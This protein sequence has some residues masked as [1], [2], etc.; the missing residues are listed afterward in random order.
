M[1]TLNYS[2]DDGYYLNRYHREQI[3]GYYNEDL[4]QYTVD[5]RYYNARVSCTDRPISVLTFNINENSFKF[6]TEPPTLEEYCTKLGTTVDKNKTSLRKLI[7]KPMSIIKLSK[8][9][10]SFSVFCFQPALLEG[11]WKEC[12]LTP[13]SEFGLIQSWFTSKE[14]KIKRTFLDKEFYA[15]LVGI[16][17]RQFV[18]NYLD[19][20]PYAEHF[21]RL[22]MGFHFHKY[23]K[24][25]NDKYF[26]DILFLAKDYLYLNLA[27]DDIFNAHAVL[28]GVDIANNEKILNAVKKLM[29]S[30]YDESE[31]FVKKYCNFVI[32][33][34]ECPICNKKLQQKIFIISRIILL[35]YPLAF[36]EEQLGGYSPYDFF[37]PWFKDTKIEYNGREYTALEACS[38]GLDSKLD[39]DALNSRFSPG[40]VVAADMLT[41]EGEIDENS[42]K[43]RAL[44]A[45]LIKHNDLPGWQPMRPI[46]IAHC[47]EDQLSPYRFAERYARLLSENGNNPN[48]RLLEV[49]YIDIDAEGLDPHFLI[50]FLMQINM[51]C[52]KEPEDLM[53]VYRPV[54]LK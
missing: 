46:Y 17:I 44:K 7:F 50:S 49:P 36:D 40:T 27:D 39:Q 37:N 15:L 23:E 41:P 24:T 47:K 3:K 28:C 51:A 19:Y 21:V 30:C 2:N 4:A 20:L 18:D 42:P 31:S 43:A 34:D 38:M 16:M 29:N 5:V 32:I 14:D 6:S 52:V 25:D 12:G 13:P 11:T 53:T 26:H 33:D 8:I 45:C 9:L 10:S 35:H 54:S 1:S 22:I 48:V